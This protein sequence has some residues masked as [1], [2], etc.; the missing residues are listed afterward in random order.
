MAS[1]NYTASLKRVLAHE[2]GYSNHPDDPGGATMRGVTQ[3][4]YD[5]FRAQGGRSKQSVSKIAEEE[6]QAIYRQQYADKV[7]FNDLPSGVDYFVFD[8]SVNS[9]VSQSVKWLQRSVGVKDDGI[10]GAVTLNAAKQQNPA[11]LIND[12]ANRRMAMLKQLTTW[13]TFGKGWT[14]RVEGARAAALEMAAGDAENAG[15][16]IEAVAWAKAMAEDVSKPRAPVV[17]PTIGAGAG[18]LGGVLETARQQIEPF[19][20]LT[21]LANQALVGLTLVSTIV[22]IGGLAYGLWAKYRRDQIKAASA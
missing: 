14:S 4:V 8:G 20:G 16:Q 1:Q 2:G 9:G 6:L 12:M 17:G 22:A 7:R 3:R 11:K 15:S 21:S 19:V 10:M 13:K 5:A 18:V